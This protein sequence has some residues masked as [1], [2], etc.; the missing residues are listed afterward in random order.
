MLIWMLLAM[1]VHFAGVFLPS[2]FL[3]PRI[4]VPAYAGSRD[5]D[6]EPT[7]MQAR[8]ARAVRNMQESLPVFLALA[9]LALIVP[10]A[11]AAQ[12]LLGAQLFVIARALYLPLYVFA[13]PYVRSGMWTLGFVGLVMMV[14]SLV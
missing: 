12:G 1:A 14:L 4:G 3:L 11:D 6:P 8:S 13:V 7:A 10:D 2:L 9:L 5:N